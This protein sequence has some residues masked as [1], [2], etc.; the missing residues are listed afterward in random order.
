MDAFK[1]SSIIDAVGNT[2]I[3]RLNRVAKGIESEI[4]VKL[5]YLNPGGS[6]KDRMGIYMAKKAEK[7]G[8]KAGGTIIECT[9]GNTGIGLA[10]Y[11]NTHGFD[12]IFVMADKQSQEKIDALRALEPK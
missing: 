11:T 10:L 3:I 7:W 1:H 2:P 12:C 6:I 9:S 5:E 4:Y 8:L